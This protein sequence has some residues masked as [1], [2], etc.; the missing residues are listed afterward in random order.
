MLRFE[1]SWTRNL[2]CR[3]WSG[4]PAASTQPHPREL[5]RNG[6]SQAPRQTYWVRICVLSKAQVS[7]KLDKWDSQRG[8]SLWGWGGSADWKNIWA[9]L[10]NSSNTL[11]VNQ[12]YKTTPQKPTWTGLPFCWDLRVPR[13]Y[14]SGVIKT[15]R[16]CGSISASLIVL[17]PQTQTFLGGAVHEVVNV[18]LPK[19]GWSLFGW[20]SSRWEMWMP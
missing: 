8:G 17:F 9:R 10:V 18:T 4:R 11:L 14:S 15:F 7:E 3:E 16:L 12:L 20:R 1:K 19:N 6:D 5:V 13:V 2:L